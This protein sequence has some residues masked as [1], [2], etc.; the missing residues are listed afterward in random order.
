MN[1]LW[2]I[3][4]DPN[5]NILRR[6]SR[7]IRNQEWPY[8]KLFSYCP[9]KCLT[10]Y[11]IDSISGSVP[12]GKT[13]WNTSLLEESAVSVFKTDLTWQREKI[14]ILPS[15][16]QPVS[17]D[18]LLEKYKV[19]EQVIRPGTSLYSTLPKNVVNVVAQLFWLSTYLRHSVALMF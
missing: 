18:G 8:C 16:C 1:I 15:T 9:L 13:I 14:N 11:V 12:W 4:V 19:T 2:I 17:P 5:L 6:S 10:V 3:L 7:L